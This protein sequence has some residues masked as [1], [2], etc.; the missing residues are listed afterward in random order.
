MT[1]PPAEATAAAVLTRPDGFPEFTLAPRIL[2]W[3]YD[4]LL[5]PDGP[6]AGQPLEWTGEQVDFIYWWY[7]ID[8][9]GR[10]IFPRGVLERMKGWGKDP[11]GAGLCSIELCGP[12]RFGGWEPDGTPKVVH[13]SAAWVQVAAVSK[14]QTR[15]TMTLFPAMLSPRAQREYQLDIGK[16]IIYAK[17]EHGRLEAVTS[18]PRAL[19]G[20]RSTLVLRNETHHWLSTNDGHDM[21]RV[22]A[23]N[24][25]KARGGGGRMLDITNAHMPG[26]DS[27]AE[28]EW[29][30][31]Q[32]TQ[33][34]LAR[35]GTRVLYD[36]REAPP[37]TAM[38]DPVSLEAGLVA[39]RGDSDWLDIPGLIETIYDPVTPVSESRRFYLNQ[40]VAPED[41]WVVPMEWDALGQRETLA[42]GELITMFFDGS[43]SDDA[44]GLVGCRF[45]DGKLFELGVWQKPTAWDD[46]HGANRWVVDRH[47]VNLLVDE[48]FEK[49][50]PVAFFGDP[51]DT[52][53]EAGERYWEAL[54]D[55]WHRKYRRRLKLWAVKTGDKQH[56]ISWDMRAPSRLQQFTEAA[57]RF[58]DDI[59]SGQLQHDASIML[60]QHIKNA[61]RRPNQY[62]V[63]IAKEHRESRN[64]IDLAVCAVGARMLWRLMTNKKPPRTS[65]P[66]AIAFT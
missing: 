36:S 62:G 47:A 43:K 42:D 25:A 8:Q 40:K 63:S 49:Y 61:R 6:K 21:A 12:C 27:V 10:W 4:Y 23:R 50:R 45:T 30:A 54:I 3:S 15:N 26:E 33:A 59:E 1:A 41:A 65:R 46:R 14:D 64:K 2:E 52:R 24:M 66:R 53:D 19:E 31:W 22:T 5:Q 16:E 44:T 58:T 55:Q 18:S 7:A 11:V 56:S 37:D 35:G 32:K 20:A 29:S 60:A 38:T 48:V 34:G 28:R 57:D 13:H 9:A 39:A 17:R 51:S